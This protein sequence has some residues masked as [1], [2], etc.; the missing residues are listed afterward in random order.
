[1]SE[2][3]GLKESLKRVAGSLLA[4]VHTRLEMLSGEMEEERLR[5]VQML[6]YGSIVFFLF[7]VAA[8]LLTAMVVVV[9]WDS[10]RLPILAGFAGMY[11]IAGMVA[12]S[13]LRRLAR[14]KSKLFSASLAELDEDLDQL[15]P[16]H[17]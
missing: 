7:G 1:M 15:A 5:V 2:S 14:E 11:L 10:Y 3:G 8:V 12:L 17:E 16:R 9:F 6:L 4:I 13:I